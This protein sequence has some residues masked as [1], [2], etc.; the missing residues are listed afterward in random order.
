[1]KEQ[2]VSLAKKILEHYYTPLLSYKLNERTNELVLEK[3]QITMHSISHSVIHGMSPAHKNILEECEAFHDMNHHATPEDIHEALK[4]IKIGKMTDLITS[5]ENKLKNPNAQDATNFT[6]N[7]L[8]K[9]A[10][11]IYVDQLAEK[12]HNPDIQDLISHL[13]NF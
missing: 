6:L 12:F 3:T 10:D 13:F 1:M 5:T 4:T 7:Q 8:E 11:K 9:K 2:K